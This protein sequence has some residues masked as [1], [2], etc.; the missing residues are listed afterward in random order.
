[1]FFFLT[2]GLLVD[3]YVKS[4]SVSPIVRAL[5]ASEGS[6]ENIRDA[7]I[8]KRKLLEGS[9][10]AKPEIPSSQVQEEGAPEAIART[11]SRLDYDGRA[12]TFANLIQIVQGLPAY[13]PNEADLKVTA[14]KTVLTDLQTRTQHI[15]KAQNALA[16]ARIARNKVLYGRGGVYETGTGVKNYIR[17]IYGMNSESSRELAK[18]VL[19]LRA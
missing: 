19:T 14:L 9:K 2:T 7:R 15:A 12:G 11:S 18:I 5:A 8:I 17:S 13:S 3:E 10:T 1:M 4:L 6:E 16:N